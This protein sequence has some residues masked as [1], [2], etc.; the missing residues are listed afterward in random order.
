MGENDG[1]K[2]H[3]K[4]AINRNLKK[5]GCESYAFLE[6]GTPGRET[7]CANVWRQW[8]AVISNTSQRSGMRYWR[9]RPGR[10]SRVYLT[11]IV[12]VEGVD[13]ARSVESF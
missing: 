9:G 1:R 3:F 8:N 2:F 6:E 11:C 13:E 7:G 12:T 5:V 10:S 4:G